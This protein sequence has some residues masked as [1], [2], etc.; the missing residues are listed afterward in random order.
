MCNIHA[1]YTYRRELPELQMLYSNVPSVHALEWLYIVFLETNEYLHFCA[2]SIF[3][4]IFILM[5]AEILFYL[6]FWLWLILFTIIHLD[7][8]VTLQ[9]QC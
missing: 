2:K 6:L 8:F 9:F 3:N 5:E 4:C 7:I 1:Q